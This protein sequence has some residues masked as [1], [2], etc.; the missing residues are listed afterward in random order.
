M[1]I[2]FGA[3]CS[4][5]V[6]QD[7]IESAI[8]A[9]TAIEGFNQCLA[10]MEELET[11]HSN[12]QLVVN[13]IQSCDDASS[14]IKL[15]GVGESL[16]NLLNISVAKA[17]ANEIVAG[18]EGLI[19]NIFQ[20]IARAISAFF[21]WI[22]NLFTADADKPNKNLAEGEKSARSLDS[23]SKSDIMNEVFPN[24]LGVK[25]VSNLTAKLG[26]IISD[27]DTA[28]KQIQFFLP[29][30]DDKSEE[31]AD[32]EVFS[33]R[34]SD[35]NKISHWNLDVELAFHDGT[36]KE[37]GWSSPEAYLASCKEL[38]RIASLAFADVNKKILLPYEKKLT[39]KLNALTRDMPKMIVVAS[40]AKVAAQAIQHI[41]L[42]AGRAAAKVFAVKR[43]CRA[44]KIVAECM[45]K[46]KS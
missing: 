12:L 3:S 8:Q 21:K 45:S 11:I 27:V 34:L 42:N 20:S 25:Y 39:D 33:Q 43:R 13:T 5:R 30:L 23:D 7:A 28:A 16:E 44:S 38:D 41:I 46:S 14:A 32:R 4:A 24:I 10:N 6:K 26:A 40:N 17:S 37:G 19:G 35:N 1:S 15:L 36:L 22:K 18:C 9:M 2:K 31:S 29:Y